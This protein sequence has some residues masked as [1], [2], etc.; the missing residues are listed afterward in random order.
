MS[1]VALV[2]VNA[3]TPYAFRTGLYSACQSGRSQIPYC[4]WEAPEPTLSF[5]ASASIWFQVQPFFGSGTPALANSSLLIMMTVASAS[6]ASAK[7]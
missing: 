7:T 3:V 5:A 4:V 2:S 6:F 1:S